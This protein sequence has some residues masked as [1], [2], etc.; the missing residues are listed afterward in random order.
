MGIQIF[1]TAS[2][3]NIVLNVPIMKLDNGNLQAHYDQPHK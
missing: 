2:P 1:E 3:G